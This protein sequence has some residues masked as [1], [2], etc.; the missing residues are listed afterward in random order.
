MRGKMPDAVGVVAEW[1]TPSGRPTAAWEG[2]LDLA[3]ITPVIGGGVETRRPDT[4][5]GIRVPALRGALRSFWRMLQPEVSAADLLERERAIWGGVG[6]SP[7][8]CL[9]SRVRVAVELVDPGRRVAAGSHTANSNGQLRAVPQWIPVVQDVAY[10]LFPLQQ[11]DETRRDAARRGKG[12]LPT[13]DIRLAMVF[14]LHLTLH[15]SDAKDLESVLSALWAC[16]HLGGVGARTTRGFGAL[17][18]R[19]AKGLPREWLARFEPPAATQARAFAASVLAGPASRP[20]DAR[21]K[22]TT[23]AGATLLVGREQQSAE[24]AHAAAVGA[25]RTFRQGVDV[26]RARGRD[27]KEGESH[28][29]EAHM[30]RLFAEEQ[31]AD[32]RWEHPPPRDRKH[33]F[34]KDGKW[35]A[36][37][38]AFGLPLIVQFKDSNDKHASATIESGHQSSRITSPVRLRP[39]ACR[40]GG[41]VPLALFLR[42]RPDGLNIRRTNAERDV[43]AIASVRPQANG[44]APPIRDYL[45]RAEGDAVDAFE[46]YLKAKDGFTEILKGGK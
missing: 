4:I 12:L 35:T 1:E 26:G 40:G 24:R 23:F 8:E 3:C 33:L 20:Y 25:L 34:K 30:L 27:R 39:L 16:V 32:V 36:P 38:A 29:P 10:A 6:D 45:D 41:Y 11:N 2:S 13:E 31:G 15:A 17:A 37:R 18:V 21:L 9:Q 44:A 28:W 42:T 43:Q 7:R 14:R 46:L 19:D 22:R 5:D